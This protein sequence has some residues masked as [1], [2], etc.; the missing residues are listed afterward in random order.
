M[1]DDVNK[2]PVDYVKPY[3]GSIG[4][5]LTATSPT[6]MLP[7]SMVQV[8]PVFT[9]GITD[10]YLA[11]KIYG[12]PVGA[13]TIMPTVNC[14]EIQPS[15]CASSFDHDFETATPYYYS[16]LLEDYDITVEYTVTYHAIYYRFTFPA[17]ANSNI[18]ISALDAG[19][20]EV[21]DFRVVKGYCILNG[22]KRYI[23]M[24]FSRPFEGYSV[25][26]EGR[27]EIVQQKAFKLEAEKTGF[28]AKYETS[29]KDCIEVK[30]G[31]SYI[32]VDQAH[33]NLVT[34]IP[35]WDFESIKSQARDIWNNALKAIEVKGGTEKQ[36]TIF[37]TALYR[38]MSRMV[39]VTEYGRYYSN[40]D[41]KVHD[42]EG[43]DFYVNDGIWDTYRCMHPLQLLIDS[44]RQ[45]DMIRSYLHIYENTGWLP[46]FPH[47]ERDLDVMIGNHAAAFILDAYMKGYRDFDVEKAYEAMKKNAMECTKLPWRKGPLTELDKVYL[48]KGFFPALDK[49]E[50][51]TVKEVHPFERRQA[52]SVTLEW[53]YD[54]WCVAQ[55]A[56]ALNK[57]EDYRYFAKRAQNYKNLYNE[58]I[59]FMAPKNAHG[60]WVK[61]FDPKLGGGLGGR[62]YTTECNSWIYTFH[63]QH[64]ID[65]L[66]DLMG[67]KE[68]FAERLDAL[69]TEQYDGPKY[70]FL[71]QFPD[72]TGLI[73]QYA[74][75]NEPSFHIPYLYNYAGQPWKT[76]RIVRKI[77]DIWYGDGPLGICGDEDGGAM[78][79]WFVF[80]AMGFYPVCPGKP[81]YDIGSP[82]FEEIKIHIDNDKVFTI[83]AINVS[84]KN[85]YI[86]SAELNGKPLNEPWIKHEDIVNGGTLVFHMGPRPNKSWGI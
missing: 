66:I 73:G 40:Y 6:V 21:T 23:Y 82:I 68:K 44:R 56:K 49:G 70:R 67:G 57:E 46:T 27:Q 26:K 72:S 42:C 10:V 30:V 16:V 38:A 1:K 83:K 11:D 60:E 77:M 76:Q 19:E 32:D 48:E 69:F 39:N 8:S 75:G 2:D 45:M 65:G 35:D 31:L 78:S 17:S 13:C 34:E 7:H 9:P 15:K 59:G 53:S 12:F 74:Q 80:S 24:E 71:G 29:D 85:K 63:V 33:R 62:D 79:S 84:S 64:D 54:D 3:I 50:E 22:M 81:V 41:K 28:A 36:R 61:D 86:Q 25:Y 20:L 47:L 52:V 55:M 37:Y 14:D 5:L 51:E 58:R 43:H 4:H 18:L